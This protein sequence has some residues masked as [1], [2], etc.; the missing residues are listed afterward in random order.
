MIRV[1]LVD[2]EQLVRSGFRM[3]LEFEDD[4]TVVGEAADGRAAIELAERAQP[5][6]ILMDIQMPRLDGLAA[7]RAIMQTATTAKIVILT[8]F[9]R[10]DY[11]YEALAAGAAGFLLKN[12]PPEQ[13]LM[14][15]RVVA[16]GDGLLSPQVTS[17]VIS[18]FVANAPSPASKD[19]I[20]HL[21]GRE[22]DVL[23][24]MTAGLNNAE[25]AADL[26]LGE[27]TIKTHVS[28]ILAKTASR[29]RIQAVV[30]GHALGL[31]PT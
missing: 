3:I 27:A 13:L 25:I 18:R 21:T 4:I 1:M 10:D 28:H 2:D 19:R 29:D 26:I 20:A 16:A 24:L 5:D 8:T 15:V 6:I 11:L 22:L 30:L 14:A 17:R 31:A 12:A 9:D 7:T 23:K